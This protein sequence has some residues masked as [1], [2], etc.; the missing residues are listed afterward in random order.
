V[1][2]THIH[3]RLEFTRRVASTEPYA[4]QVRVGKVFHTSNIPKQLQLSFWRAVGYAGWAV[5]GAS[6][7]VQSV[8]AWSPQSGGGAFPDLTHWSGNKVHIGPA[9]TIAHQAPPAKNDQSEQLNWISL[10]DVGVGETYTLEHNCVMRRGYHFQREFL[11]YLHV[12]RLFLG[13]PACLA[14]VSWSTCTS[15]A[16]FLEYLH[17]LRLLLGVPARLAL[18]S[19]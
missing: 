14:L 6:F 3:Q 12:L 13:V 4:D 5:P 7:V 11:E 1:G 10:D 8:G 15:C 18:V 16:C 19:R 2:E 9:F 17:V